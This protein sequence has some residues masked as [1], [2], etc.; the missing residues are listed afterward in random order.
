MRNFTRI[1]KI[2]TL[3]IAL[4]ATLAVN[5]G[6]LGGKKTTGKETVRRPAGKPAPKY[7][8]GNA[9]SFDGVD[10]YVSI[11][12]PA[13][14]NGDFTWE[15]WVKTSEGGTIIS[16]PEGSGMRAFFI[17]DGKLQLDVFNYSVV[18][19]TGTYNDNQWHHVAVVVTKY[20]SGIKFY[21]DG[22]LDGDHNMTVD[23]YGSYTQPTKIGYGNSWFPSPT[24]FKGSMDEVRIWSVAR[25]AEQI[26]ES[27]THQLSLPQSNLDAYYTFNEGTPNGN[28]GSI[29][30]LTDVTGNNH[31]GNLNGFDLSGTSSNWIEESNFNYPFAPIVT[32]KSN[33]ICQ[34]NNIILTATRGLSYQ[35]YKDGAIINGATSRTYQ[36]SEAGAYTVAVQSATGEQVVS[37]PFQLS[38]VANELQL[39]IT[40]QPS[41]TA[42]GTPTGSVTLTPSG[43]SGQYLIQSVNHFF[44][45]GSNDLSLFNTQVN[46]PNAITTATSEGFTVNPDMNSYNWSWNSKVF[47]QDVAQLPENMVAEFSLKTEAYNN[48]LSIGVFNADY[49]ADYDL[50]W[51]KY[52]FGF[53][54]SY[55]NVYA[56]FNNGNN[57]Y[58]TSISPNTW[59]DLKLEKTG[60]SVKY[61]IR[62]TGATEYTLYYTAALNSNVVTGMN[63]YIG[64]SA[65][66]YQNSFSG[67]SSKDWKFIGNPRTTGLA[68]GTYTFSLTD[69]VTGCVTTA[70]ATVGVE[71]SAVPLPVVFDVTGTGAYCEGSDAPHIRLSGSATDVRYQL[72][73]G[74]TAI[75]DP[76]IGTGDELDFGAQAENGVYTIKAQNVAGNC[77]VVMNGS[78]TVEVLGLPQAVITPSGSLSFC[79]GVSITLTANNESAYL[80]SNGSQSQ[81]INVA[82]AG[83][84]S[85]TVTGSNGCSL[86]SDVITTATVPNT[87]SAA[88]AATPV[89]CANTSDGTVTLT[90]SG[91]SGQY[92][93]DAFSHQ[94]TGNTLSTSLFDVR[95]GNFSQNDLLHANYDANN[96]NWSWDNSISTKQTFRF[97]DGADM[98]AEFRLSNNTEMAFGMVDASTGSITDPSQ[99]RIGFAVS[100]FNLYT[101]QNG[102]WNYTGYSGNNNWIRLRIVRSGYNMAYY[103]SLNGEPYIMVTNQYYVSDDNTNYKMAALY[104]E[105]PYSDSWFESKNWRFGSSSNVITGLSA[106]TYSYL[107]KDAVTGCAVTTSVTVPVAP[108]PVITPSV[109]NISAEGA[110][111]GSVVFTSSNGGTLSS[112][113]QLFN[114]PFSGSSLNTNLFST[115][116]APYTENGGHLRVNGNST[117]AYWDNSIVTTQSFPVTDNMVFE[118]S[119]KFDNTA[120]VLFG[121]AINDGTNTGDHI[122]FAAY[123]TQL[124]VNEFGG[125]PHQVYDY[126]PN[127]WYDFKV[128]KNGNVYKYY[129]KQSTAADWNH[130]Y[131]STININSATFKLGAVHWDR[132][133]FGYGG[134]NTKNWKL[135]TGSEQ[136]GLC[137]GTY[138]YSIT[139]AGGCSQDVT[140]TIGYGATVTTQ[141][142]NPSCFGSTNGSITVNATGGTAP[143]QYSINGGETYVSTHTF[144]SLAA[145]TYSVLVKDASE[146][147]SDAQQVILTQPAEVIAAVTVEGV[148]TFCA[149]GSVLLTSSS[150]TGNLWSNGETT[151]S[152]TVNTSGNYS[153]TVTADG[154]TATSEA[155]SVTVN[156]LPV[157]EAITGTTTLCAGSNTQLANATTGGIWSSSDITVA[158]VSESGNIT[159]LEPGT[160]IISYTVTANGCATAVTTT[161][162]VNAMPVVNAITGTT[163]VC[164]NAT[165]QL[166]NTTEGGVW[167]SSNSS[168]ATVNASGLV[169]GVAAGDAVISYTVTENGCSVSTAITVKVSAS[170]VINT[171]ANQVV[172]TGS[173]TTAVNFSGTGNAYTWTNS[174]PSVG[175]AAS[176]S[177]NLASFLAVNNTGSPVTATI[178]VIPASSPT[179]AYVTNYFDGKLMAVDPTTN[180][181]LATI[182]V[183]SYPYAIALTP[184][185]SRV[186]VSNLADN[187]MSVVNTSNN[188]VTDIPM[189]NYYGLK[190]IA[191][192]PDGSKVYVPYNYSNKLAVISTATNTITN[193]ITVGTVAGGSSGVAVSPDGSRVY[194]INEYNN[195][196]TVIDAATNTVLTTVATGMTPR[197]IAVSADGTRIYTTN[198]GPNNPV[199][200]GTVTVINAS[201]NTV[202]TTIPVGLGA[203]GVVVSPD[204]SKVYVTNSVGGNIAVIN[205]ATNTVV[206]TI[207][208][209]IYGRGLN[210][211][212]D[213][214]KLYVAAISKFVT[215]NTSDNSVANTMLMLGNNT[216]NMGN[217][218]KTGTGCTGAPTTFTITVNPKP[219]AAITVTGSTTFCTGGSVL[220]SANEGE[221]LTYQW[222][223]DG[224]NIQY[225][226]H[227]TYTANT[228]GNYTVVV[229]NGYGCS[230]ISAAVN[231][232]VNPLPTAVI[233][234]NGPAEVCT[235][236][237]VELT[238]NAASAYQWYKDGIAI[239]GAVNASYA[240]TASGQYSVMVTNANNCSATSTATAVIVQDLVA[241]TVITQNVSRTITTAT[242]AFTVTVADIDNG[243]YDNCTIVSKTLGG[244]TTFDCTTPSGVYEVTLIIKDLAGNTSSATATVTIT[245]ACN[246]PPSILCAPILVY[247]AAGTCAATVSGQ[248]LATGNDPDG[249]VLTYTLSAAGPFNVGVHTVTVTVTDPGGLSASCTTT[250]TV[251]DNLAPVPVVTNLPV[252]TGECSVAVTTVPKATDNCTGPVTGTTSDPLNY[253]VQ[254][255]YTI[256]WKYTDSYG[257]SSTQTQTVIVKDNTAPVPT[258]AVLPTITGSC[259]AGITL[260]PIVSGCQDDCRCCRN[261]C[262]CRTSSCQCRDYD[263]RLR[264]IIRYLY[265]WLN[266]HFGND[267][268]DDHGCDSDNN[269]GG[270]GNIQYMAAPKATDNCKGTIIG[271]TTDPL[272]YSTPGTHII[273]WKFDDGYGNI[274]VQ[275]Q[276]VIVIDNTAPV[277][278]VSNLPT[279]TGQCSVTIGGNGSDD[280]D[281]D[282]NWGPCRS[283]PSIP[284]AKDNCAGLIYGST[285][286]PLSYNRAGTYTIRWSYN[287]GNG[288]ITTQTQTVIVKD[289]SAPKPLVKN[290]PAISA[291]CSV[292]VNVIPTAK[293]NCVGIINGTT[294]DPLTYTVPGVYTIRW[295]YNDGNGNS[296]T[297]TQTITIVDNTKPVLN[298]P[299][300]IT[301]GCNISTLPSVTGIA[302]ATDN[303]STPVVSYT[304]HVSGNLITRTWRATDAAGNY[305]TDVQKITIGLSFDP[306]ITSVPTNS[307]YTGGIATNL[308][309]GYGA[310]STT[311]QVCTL[312]SAGAPYTYAWAGSATGRLNTTSSSAPV[313]T[314]N[315]YGTFTFIVTV[316]NKYGCSYSDNITICVTDIRVPGTGG[317][318]VYVCHTPSGRNKTPQT[319]QV[320]VAQV[321]SHIN[322]NCGSNG[323]DRL[324]SCDQMPCNTNGLTSIAVTKQSVTAESAVSEKVRTSEEELKVT[325]MPNPSTTFFTLK[326]ESKYET[327]VDLRVMDGSGRVVDARS[328]LGAN[329]TLQI[330]HSYSSGTY[331]AELIQG[332]RR[333]VVQLIKARG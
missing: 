169:S 37:V 267:D 290:L 33:S 317:A 21:V 104:V 11:G 251:K 94:F 127:T 262:H 84:F 331:Y 174:T 72:Y 53:Y 173:L 27:M 329:S 333:K 178:T 268:D 90:A 263:Y 15:A 307:V 167:S 226:T 242:G 269:T 159:A 79:E 99:V 276:R 25:T 228:A 325:V 221:G 282:H 19:T 28:N 219:A 119:F 229:T 285:S 224:V 31:N 97:I 183:G 54:I 222:K 157:V 212:A 128:E 55:N 112:S 172:C 116:N 49:G 129:L 164:S 330:G 103:I 106:G 322:S 170:P 71:E 114:Y 215:I 303:C 213:G 236:G 51:W 126:V 44:A 145:G 150:A 29:N 41:A 144:N 230:A 100:G 171:V 132:A 50:T 134:Y 70:T 82:A 133:G 232:T 223:K 179:T 130:V 210:I 216:F 138:T 200:N 142:V 124:Y 196:V 64:S 259:S 115:R 24:Y 299:N 155:I 59:Y 32:G 66:F 7:T 237:T 91:G 218:I 18:A 20:N 139:I 279:I 36:V 107:V 6:D 148:T 240:A 168:I 131:T 102:G 283:Y 81:S 193:L 117:N 152:I 175:L 206:A 95:N 233:T 286:D 65:L 188:T 247:T 288:N 205:T 320:P 314:P 13:G 258:V 2:S 62:N 321:A 316:T 136:T 234:V 186:Y 324:G 315:S 191:M 149:G 123:E 298:E 291:S 45:P 309:I 280:D 147:V 260:T 195:N 118:S 255:T 254:G 271:T 318:K 220:L 294:T 207:G 199:Q 43:G 278:T 68:A 16:T 86:T 143:Y 98:E 83:S 217:F 151:P 47:T 323:N 304:D 30:G 189:G 78:V 211:S 300:D 332:G 249:D 273:H 166:N 231:V 328:K 187:K 241:P 22:I 101:I 245:N 146:V 137:A 60:N 39:G 42:C 1:F 87:L 239:E 8:G 75:G 313:F 312:S 182:T 26:Q 35:W 194:V 295:K 121:L 165:T 244:T 96:A 14:T 10:D 77:I 253:T 209:D 297:Q 109:T 190:G 69:A 122:G 284:T 73:R 89:S 198:Y 214:S 74:Q 153:V 67:Y 202:V 141:Q 197:G 113:T 5:A 88:V 140:F 163:A 4:F 238:A 154:C 296:T 275:E 38:I 201:N 92:S 58:I 80:W 305:V 61:Y 248:Q 256:T 162:T 208:S 265:N 261:G 235:G 306:V 308:Y 105:K 57:N 108:L 180:T 17:R 302:T 327:P 85:V 264:G 135:S 277:P 184:D 158:T 3:F 177:G 243:S 52:A 160:S 319:L 176:G 34:G 63:Y 227:A 23:Y 76:V 274:T 272:T 252:I 125:W 292:T 326:L 270:N 311:L 40:T 56:S 120:I 301:I 161:V 9:L 246:R 203:H 250:I 281:E 310:Q 181:T 293:D 46:S 192:S 257:N 156:P 287:D 110:C 93:Y 204:N 111:D 266:D 48:E 289:Q 12:N 225:E 185:G